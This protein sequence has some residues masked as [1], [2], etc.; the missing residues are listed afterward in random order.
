MNNQKLSPLAWLGIALVVAVALMAVFG[1]VSVSTTGGYYGMM[2]TGA[3]GWAMIFM[4]VPGI[5]L[6]L[7][8]VLALGGLSE[9][10]IYTPYPYVPPT[11]SAVEILDQRYAR[12]EL[13]REDYLRMRTELGQK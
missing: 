1:A 4:A 9:R 3:W 2:G 7:V 8:L 12:G 13:G 11:S 10:P 6:I 5:I